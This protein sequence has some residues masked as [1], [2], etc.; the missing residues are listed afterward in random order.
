MPDVLNHEELWS[1]VEHDRELLASLV[2]VFERRSELVLKSLRE[3]LMAQDAQGLSQD[4]HQ[5][6]GMLANLSAARALPI[7]RDLERRARDGDLR[8]AGLGC[9]QL[10]TEIQ[11]VT[12]ALAT[13]LA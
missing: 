10:Q 5:L 9:Q 11:A 13:L 8:E 2:G 12:L 4:A 6:A 3:H 1:R 7:A